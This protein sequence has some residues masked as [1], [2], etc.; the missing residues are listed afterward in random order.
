M[1]VPRTSATTFMTREAE[2]R[3]RSESSARERCMAQDQRLS[4]AEARRVNLICTLAVCGMLGLLVLAFLRTNSLLHF[5]ILS[6]DSI[7]P[8]FLSGLVL[9]VLVG[10][11]A[12]SHLIMNRPLFKRNGF[13]KGLSFVPSRYA[14]MIWPLMLSGFL[15]YCRLDGLELY[16]SWERDWLSAG[17]MVQ[18]DRLETFSFAELRN[19]ANS[20]NP[21]ARQELEG[22]VGYLKGIFIPINDK[23]FS[24]LNRGRSGEVASVRVIGPVDLSKSR[25]QANERVKAKG[26]LEFR[27]VEDGD[28]GR[29]VP[30][31]VLLD[32]FDLQRLDAD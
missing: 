18:E 27:K 6:D 22:K 5:S 28:P 30:V 1:C 29:F 3:V 31:L 19:A 15:V 26:R 4:P 11:H 13:D 10:V 14:V 9:V 16:L 25:F 24:V 17:R 7:R 12:V 23:E 8:V 32:V 21:K 2:A 20:S